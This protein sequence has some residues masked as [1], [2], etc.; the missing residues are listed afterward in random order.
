MQNSHEKVERNKGTGDR[1]Q[2]TGDREEGRGDR[3]EGRGKREE[4][5]GK[6][7]IRTLR[8]LFHLFTLPSPLA[9]VPFVPMLQKVLLNFG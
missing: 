8:P 6:K 2:G 3:E 7:D 9:P 4:G 5:R 1:G